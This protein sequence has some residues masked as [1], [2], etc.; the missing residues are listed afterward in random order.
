MRNML[1][2]SECV[3]KAAL[4][5]TESR[6][7]HTRDDHPDMDANWRN[8]PCWCA[9]LVVA[10]RSC[11]TV[12][13]VAEEQTPMRDRP[14]GALQALGELDEVLHRCRTGPS[15]RKNARVRWPPMDAS[16]RVWR[17]DATGGEL[18]DYTVEVNDG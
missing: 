1:L 5:R 18:K 7:G 9:V 8:S 2:V 10:I 13:V 17:G 15:T 12:T 11:P 3:A 16:L 4:Q 6:G 14:A